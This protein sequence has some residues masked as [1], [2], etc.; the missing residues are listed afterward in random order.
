MPANLSCVIMRGNVA[1]RRLLVIGLRYRY[2]VGRYSEYRS[3]GRLSRRDPHG[4]PRGPRP[5]AVGVHRLPLSLLAHRA[6]PI[7]ERAAVASEH[8][9]R[10]RPVQERGAGG[11][12]EPGAAE[13]RAQ[14]AGV[15]DRGAGALR[16]A[17]VAEVRR[18]TP[19]SSAR[20][21]VRGLHVQPGA[22]GLLTSV[23]QQLENGSVTVWT[24]ITF[25]PYLPAMR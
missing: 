25:Q 2:I 3:A 23:G 21:A 8:R 14:R 11:D 16:A 15:G 17:T 5:H 13:A 20:H 9:H 4:R 18:A 7:P 1:P 22:V 12:A 19:E 10:D 24:S 6:V